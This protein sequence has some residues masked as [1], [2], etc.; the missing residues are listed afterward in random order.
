MTN[1]LTG[2]A[3]TLFL[4]R[5]KWQL[6]LFRPVHLLN[7]LHRPQLCLR[8]V[9]EQR[10]LMHFRGQVLLPYTFMFGQ[11]KL[12]QKQKQKRKA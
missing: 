9:T 2:L 12:Q 7:K 1:M 3:I 4:T 6:R 10:I 5:V 11:R 8:L